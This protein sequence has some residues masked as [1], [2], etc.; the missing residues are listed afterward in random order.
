MEL[1]ARSGLLGLWGHEVSCPDPPPGRAAVRAA[2]RLLPPTL[3]QGWL[4][5]CAHPRVTGCGY[6]AGH[7]SPDTPAPASLSSVWTL[8]RFSSRARG[9]RLG[10]LRRGC[11]DK[12]KY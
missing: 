3:L 10:L 8:H 5:R 11:T 6:P 2:G 12:V 7:S 4:L 9:P 1:R